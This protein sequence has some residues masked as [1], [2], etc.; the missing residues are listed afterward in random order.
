MAVIYVQPYL[1]ETEYLVGA[2]EER[3][4]N[5]AI[6]HDYCPSVP[7][8]KIDQARHEL[9]DRALNAWIVNHVVSDGEPEDC[10]CVL[11]ARS[12]SNPDVSRRAIGVNAVGRLFALNT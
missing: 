2:H 12:I 6:R 8:E 10:A 3:G 9:A 1:E 7:V 4:G 5:R 11:I